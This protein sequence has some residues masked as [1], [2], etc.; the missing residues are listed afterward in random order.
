MIEN[1]VNAQFVLRTCDTSNSNI[2]LSNKVKV[3]AG[4]QAVDTRT[5]FTWL[6]VDLKSILGDLWYQYEYFDL[7]LEYLVTDVITTTFTTQDRFN[8]MYI[9][10]L[11][12]SNCNYNPLTKT[13]RA[14]VLLYANSWKSISATVGQ[15]VQPHLNNRYS[16][17]KGREQVDIN[18]YIPPSTVN[19][20]PNMVFIFKIFPLKRFEDT[21]CI[22][23]CSFSLKTTVPNIVGPYYYWNNIDAKTL[24]GGL[25]DKFDYFSLELLQVDTYS[26][27]ASLPT[28][29]NVNYI[30]IDGLPFINDY[31]IAN[32]NSSAPVGILQYISD[33]GITNVIAPAQGEFYNIFSKNTPLFNIRASLYS[34]ATGAITESNNNNWG[35]PSLFFKIKGV[36]ID[37]SM[38]EYIRK[39]E[40]VREIKM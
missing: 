16:F 15:V 39:R 12:W 1:T 35:F 14:E 32:K 29:A 10:G 13:N 25:Y 36:E 21:S 38:K 23:N 5:N 34:V 28:N 37:S 7:A 26:T 40:L 2:C 4:N 33:I 27:G 30:L 9:S 3:N 8:N 17:K 20:F 11:Q 31:D 24:M 22:L 19:V 6:S 18:I